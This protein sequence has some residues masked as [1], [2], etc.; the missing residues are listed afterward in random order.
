MP[1]PPSGPG[2]EDDGELIR[3]ELRR[4]YDRIR[5]ADVSSSDEAKFYLDAARDL[6]KAARR[7]PWATETSGLWSWPDPP[8]R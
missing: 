6:Y 5:E 7:T 1:P 4:A 8:R 3:R 2:R